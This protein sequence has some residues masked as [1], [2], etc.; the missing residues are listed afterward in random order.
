M[1]VFR[2][3][4]L[5]WLLMFWQGG[6][7]FY[8]G[9]VIAVGADVLGGNFEQGLITR[10]VTDWLNLSGAIVLAVWIIDLVAERRYCLKRRWTAWA[11]M[12]ATLA[13]LALLHPVMEKHIGTNHLIQREIFN[14]LHAWYL[15]MSTVQ[16]LA[17]IAFTYWTLQNW[18]K[19]DG[20]PAEVLWE[21]RGETPSRPH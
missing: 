12:V 6:F 7:M 4:V 13:A 11:I 5:L 9:V 14:G 8:G 2:R 20:E 21:E 1:S 16:W 15:R 3:L 18:R 19:S 10:H 17:A